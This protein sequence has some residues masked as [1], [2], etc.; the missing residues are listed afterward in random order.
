[1]NQQSNGG[2]EQGSAHPLKQT[3]DGWTALW[4][5]QTGL[6]CCRESLDTQ[7][8]QRC[9]H[10]DVLIVAELDSQGRIQLPKQLRTIRKG[11]NHFSQTLPSVG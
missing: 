4:A 6:A 2:P 11:T 1:M 9:L 7:H 3:S 8:A 5:P 10:L